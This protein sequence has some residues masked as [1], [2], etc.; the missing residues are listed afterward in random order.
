M[1]LFMFFLFVRFLLSR[2]DLSSSGFQWIELSRRCYAKW[3]DDSINNDAN[4]VEN[5]DSDNNVDSD[6]NADDKEFYANVHQ[7]GEW[8]EQDGRVCERNQ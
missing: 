1:L 2:N 5:E 7:S 6:S 8:N 3:C 4:N